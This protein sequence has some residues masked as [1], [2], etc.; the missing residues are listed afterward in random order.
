MNTLLLLV[1]ITSTV[2]PMVSAEAGA[3][4]VTFTAGGEVITSYRHAGTVQVEK[5]E[6]TKPL[7]KPYFY[8]LH[9]PGAIKVTRDWPI[10]R[11]RQG[12][13][14][15]HFHQKSAWFCHGDVI[16][17]GVELKT[18]SGD[19]HVKGVDFWAENAGHGRIVC[20]RVTL[21]K[22]DDGTAKVSTEN[23]WQTPDAV[24]ILSERR[25]LRVK[26]LDHGYL[27]EVAIELE[28]TVAAVTF[29]DTKEGSFGVRVPDS[30]RLNGTGTTGV[31]TTPD[32]TVAKAPAR[33]NLPMWGR[34][35][36]W[37][38][39]S[40]EVGGKPVGIAVFAHPTNRLP[41]AWHTRAYGL[42]AANPFGR[43]V[44]G[45]PDAKDQAEAFVLK[46]GETLALKF[47]IYTHLGDA[48]AGMV[49][50]VYAAYAK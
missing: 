16:P 38:D 17:Q 32:G 6:G 9:A 44:A 11:G 43:K 22:A 10:L 18:K 28:P 21:L 8:P 23:T 2:P 15:D 14:V 19:K 30:F 4:A 40:G 27:I 49:A 5:G 36:A 31:V 25:T 42:M 47:A 13:T 7:A 41:S 3:D 34:H 29:G 35:A 33:D 50:D 46:K 24:T 48:K 39:Y 26:A 45:F 20:D 12:E 1:T 37:N